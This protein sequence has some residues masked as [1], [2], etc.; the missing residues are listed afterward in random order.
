MIAIQIS[1]ATNPKHEANLMKISNL[2][3][4]Q[5]ASAAKA[6]YAK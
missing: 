2:T 1:M 3:F 6:E 5:R 4:A